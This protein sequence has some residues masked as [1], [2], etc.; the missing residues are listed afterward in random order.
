MGVESCEEAGA[1]DRGEGVILRPNPHTWVPNAL[2]HPLNPSVT[3]V[4]G[5]VT[6]VHRRPNSGKAAGA[7]PRGIPFRVQARGVWSSPFVPLYVCTPVNVRAPLAAGVAARQVPRI[8]RALG[9]W[10]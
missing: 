2:W 6:E 10:V 7:D 5:P 1:A 3:S 4:T 8:P 9:R